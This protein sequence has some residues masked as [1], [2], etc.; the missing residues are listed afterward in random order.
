LQV[1]AALFNAL[2]TLTQC[3]VVKLNVL[4]VIKRY[5]GERA[6]EKEGREVCKEMNSGRERETKGNREMK[7]LIV[8]KYIKRKK[9]ME[10]L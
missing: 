8:D 5:E 1:T 4:R 10:T 2:P 7:G 9:G 3:N 6:S